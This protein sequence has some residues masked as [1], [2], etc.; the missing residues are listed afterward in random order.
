MRPVSDSELKYLRRWKKIRK[1]KWS[2]VCRNGI[3]GGLL[4]AML[5]YLLVIRFNFADFDWPKVLIRCLLFCLG[6]CITTLMHFRAQDKRYLRV[7]EQ[8]KEEF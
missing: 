3:I 4:F 2:Y 5:T 6:G 7:L 8:H 1:N